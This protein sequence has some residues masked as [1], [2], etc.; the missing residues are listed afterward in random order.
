MVRPLLRRLR[1][2]NLQVQT[3]LGY[4]V[5]STLV[6]LTFSKACCKTKNEKW[7]VIWLSGRSALLT[8]GPT[9]DSHTNKPQNENESNSY[10]GGI[11]SLRVYIMLVVQL[12]TSKIK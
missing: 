12:F 2:G 10:H 4:R 1:Q 9:F 7:L 6:W 8:Q 5:S 11:N 3:W